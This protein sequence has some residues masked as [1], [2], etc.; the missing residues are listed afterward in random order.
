[1]MPLGP[2]LQMGLA[3]KLSGLLLIEQMLVGDD[4]V[5]APKLVGYPLVGLLAAASMIAAVYLAGRLRHAS[6]GTLEATPEVGV[7]PAVL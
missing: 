2:K 1:M 5:A 4:R 7:E 3:S 6:V